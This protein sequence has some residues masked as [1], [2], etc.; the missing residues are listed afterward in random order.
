MGANQL[1]FDI[2]EDCVS[3]LVGNNKSATLKVGCIGKHYERELYI[4]QVKNNIPL[5]GIHPAR[6]R[7]SRGNQKLG[8]NCKMKCVSAMF[9]LKSGITYFEVKS[10][11]VYMRIPI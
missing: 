6:A 10:I 1:K 11:P 3:C 2:F 5:D 8:C 9:F 4:L 7:N